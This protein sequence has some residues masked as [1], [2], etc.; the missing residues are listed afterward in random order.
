MFNRFAV[1]KYAQKTLGSIGEG[2]GG[3]YS[4]SDRLG[5]VGWYA[6]NSH[7]APPAAQYR[8]NSATFLPSRCSTFKTFN[9][10]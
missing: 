7:G 10:D 3:A 1:K 5:E 4:G 8:K 2:R 6:A 9:F